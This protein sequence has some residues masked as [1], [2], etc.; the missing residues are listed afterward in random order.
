MTGIEL[1][2]AEGWHRGELQRW[3]RN[4][5]AGIA[6]NLFAELGSLL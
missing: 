2:F 6:K 5:I 3:L 4:E 1:P